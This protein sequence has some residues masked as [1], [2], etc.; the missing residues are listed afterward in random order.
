MNADQTFPKRVFLV[1]DNLADVELSRLVLSESDMVGEVEVAHDGVQALQVLRGLDNEALPHFILLDLNM[2]RMDGRE[3][4]RNLKEDA[5]LR[6]I[7]VI[8]L[9]TSRAPRDVAAAYDSQAAAY[10]VKPVDLSGFEEIVASL[11]AFWLARVEY[12]EPDS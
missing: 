11:E 6:R 4:L 3:F 1:E 2:P 10:L 12:P 9:T 5:R 8:V 7:P